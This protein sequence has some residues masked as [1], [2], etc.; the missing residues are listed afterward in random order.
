MRTIDIHRPR[1]NDSTI[2]TEPAQGTRVAK[3]S[4]VRVLVSS[5]PDEIDVPNV[6]GATTQNATNALFAQGFNVVVQL[7]TG[8]PSGIV[9]NQNP[10][11]GKLVKG[12]TVTIFAG[13]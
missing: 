2:G 4:T 7:V 3:G 8:R 9:F 5:G 13:Q 10:T 11:G 12:G 1:L 6:I